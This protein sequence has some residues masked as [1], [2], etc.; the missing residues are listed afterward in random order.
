MEVVFSD[1]AKAA[2]MWAV[3]CNMNSKMKIGSVAGLSFLLDV[4]DIS[5]EVTGEA[6]TQAIWNLYGSAFSCPEDASFRKFIHGVAD[7]LKRVCETAKR[8][9][10]IR[11]WHSDAPQD[12]CGLRHLLWEIRDCKCP[13]CEVALPRRAVRADGVV[14]QQSSW[15]CVEPEEFCRY[16]PQ[17]REIPSPMRNVLAQEWQA[18]VSENAPLRACVSGALIGVDADFYDVFLRHC[19][20]EGEFRMAQWIGATLGRYDL[21]VGDGWYAMRIRR[22][23]DLGEIEVV[24]PGEADHPYSAW[25]RK[26][27]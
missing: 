16:L 24:R 11:I 3:K 12:A 7:D 20:P 9:E 25:L 8:G 23:I 2:L 22:M 6:R 26:T 1:S 5:G 10:A 13:V 4:G 15:A 27:V 18:M 19:M 21:G 17:A 14:V